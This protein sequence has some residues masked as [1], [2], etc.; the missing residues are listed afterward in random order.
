MSTT[1]AVTINRI[2]WQI[3]AITLVLFAL[4]VSLIRGLLP[5]VP[6]VR[7]ELIGYLQN[8]YQLHVQMDELSAEWQA[9]GP[10]LTVKNLVLPPQDN[11]PIT[12][13]SEN[14]HI[15][16]D[17]WQSLFTL[18]PQVETVVFD[19]VKVALN[20]DELAATDEHT[21]ATDKANLDWLYGLLL[22]QLGHFSITDASLQLVSKQHDYR[23]IFI[24]NLVWQNSANQHQAQGMIHVDQLQSQQEQLTLR[25]DLTGDGYLPDTVAG[26]LYVTADS[27]DL[28]EW[29]SRQHSVQTD[30]DNIEFQGVINLDA[31]M[32]FAHRQ[33]SD[34]IL[35]FKPSWL[36]WRDTD[37]QQKFAINSGSLQWT[38]QPDGWKIDSHDLDLSTND[39]TWPLLTLAIGTREGDFFGYA[40]QI[41]PTLLKPMLPL[42]PG[43]GMQQV[44]SWQQLNPQGQIGPIRLYKPAEK[45]LIANVEVQQLQWQPYQSIPGISPIDAQLIWA[46]NQLEFSL[47]EQEYKLDFSRDIS[48]PLTF[49]GSAMKGQ[50]DVKQQRLTV[51]NIELSNDD[52]DLQAGLNL[53]F[54]D[55]THMGLAAH[56]SINDVAQLG[57]YFPLMAMSPKLIDYLNE[58]LVAGQVNDAQVVWHGE[59]GAYPYQ[60]NSGVFQA[61]FTLDS[62]NFKFQSNWP[63]VSD[64]TLSALFE[65]SMMNLH[66]DQGK[67]DK[68]VVDGARVSIPHLGKESLLRVEADITTDAQA[69]T[70]VI[71]ASSLRDSVGAT[72][73]VVQIQQ[74]INTTLDLSIPL[75]E[76]GEQLIKGLVTFDN[77]PVFI[78]SPGLDLQ[79]VTGQVSFVNQVIEGKNITAQLFQQPLTFSLNT[80]KRNNNVALNVAMKGRW[81]LDA[82]P[83][84][85]H[86]PLT[87][88]YHG[89]IDW[90]GGVSM[91]FD[92]SGYSLQVSVNSDL[93]G[94][95]LNLPMPY[96]K[97]A[98][99]PRKLSADLIGDNK[100]SSLSI[101]LG[102]DVEFWGGFNADNGS[103]LAFY[104]VMIGRHFRLGDKLKKQQGHIHL[105]L[106][107]VDLA[108]WLPLIN[109]F[110]ATREPEVVTSLIR[111]RILS[112]AEQPGAETSTNIASSVEAAIATPAFPPLAGIHADIGQLNVLGQS[113][114]K[115]HF[116]AQPTEHVWRFDAQSQ[117]FEGRID[118]YPN[119]HDQGIKVVAKKLHLFPTV[120]TTESV[121]LTSTSMLQYLPTLAI[122]VDDFSVSKLS[123]GHLV[124]Q[125]LPHE[126]G[127]QFQTISLTKPT[128][129]LQANGL[130]S[131]ENGIDNTL[132]DVKLQAE[133]FDD[134]SA[135]LNI[136]PGL[137]DAP[138]DLSG[139]LSWQGAPYHFTL[140]TLNGQLAFALGK[141]H[142]SEISDK[143]A[144]VFSL[145]S[146]DSLL[147]KLSLD[148]SDVFGEGL[149]FNTFNGN[150]TIDNGV[151]K[152][153]DS[154]MDAIAGNM[155][156]RGY[157]DLTTQSLNYDIRFV[158][159]LASSVP[160]VVLLSTSAWTLGLGAFALTKVLEP[161]IE[162]I[163]EIRFRVTGTMDNPQLEELERKSKEIEIPQAILPQADETSVETHLGTKANATVEAK[164][165]MNKAAADVK[166]D[167]KSAHART[168]SQKSMPLTQVILLIDN[169]LYD[170]PLSVADIDVESI[171]LP[172]I[173]PLTN[174]VM[175]Q[176]V[177]DAN[178]LVTMS[179]QS[180]CQSQSRLCRLAA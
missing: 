111:D 31:W 156:V 54:I 174:I 127:Y 9:F 163:S 53:E 142:L 67:L 178:Q 85:L 21:K 92:P 139:Q 159:Q 48:Q 13:I 143:G 154:E 27:L 122:D 50:Y 69:A 20:L 76:G 176:G 179:K 132:F 158:P 161:V 144:R 90:S 87:E 115:L 43:L 100:Q 61:A 33:I 93:V 28:G 30:S 32:T 66:I 97:S 180:R 148:F 109:R 51:P 155:R 121:D 55:Q 169:P 103:Q 171:R 168:N 108:Q 95:S 149:Y 172:L 63:A 46:N 173:N 49:H 170:G 81:D 16:L 129:A 101:K 84:S 167:N 52:L 128:V 29:A 77:N 37:S 15:K 98:T 153:T 60:D 116:D 71:N 112:V 135:I 17:F 86:N 1:Q 134:L 152:T 23:P 11:L 24:D 83:A 34:G 40:S 64:L 22:E 117:Q 138:L 119:W 39:Q 177:R 166:R 56:L 131:V 62:G 10:A 133:K 146:L 124:L 91:V 38:P 65:N 106:P 42:V 99:E 4:V 68:V 47:P 58:G 57:R 36:Q 75:Y 25:I 137:E 107:K 141:G 3:L 5:H 14:V 6:E 96:Q 19:G 74:Q 73:D 113:F 88:T 72:L 8:E 157:T 164:A 162:V 150:L 80:G 120:S 104:D 82:L 126:Q 18:S 140:D 41:I 94:T 147:R 44:R 110:S 78:D 26:Q 114:D 45:P 136:N 35:V 123:L 2:F 118:F 89:N 70:N 130:W 59:V 7:T 125:G 102:N 145:F 175:L 151:V 165:K 12:V 79:G 160:T 105:D